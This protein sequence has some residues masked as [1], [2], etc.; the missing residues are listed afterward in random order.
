MVL[1]GGVAQASATGHPTSTGALAAQTVSGTAHAKRPFRVRAGRIYY[2][3][4]RLHGVH[5][6][7]RNAVESYY[8]HRW[9]KLGSWRVHRGEH[10]FVGKMRA[11]HPGLYKLRLQF[12]RH[13]HLLRGSASN[14]FRVRVLRF[15]HPKVRH[16]PHGGT[17]T[18]PSMRLAQPDDV[19][20]DWNSAE[21]GVGNN[22]GMIGLGTLLWIPSPLSQQQ[23][24]TFNV[25]QVIWVRDAYPGGNYG[26]WYV[27][28]TD[29]QSIHPSDPNIITITGAGDIKSSE[30][31]DDMYVNYQAANEYHQIAWD[32]AVQTSNGWQYI[33]STAY[34]PNSYVQWDQTGYPSGT[35]QSQYCY[36]Y[37]NQGPQ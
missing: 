35:Y 33:A 25:Y 36:T 14:S 1:V 6:G 17:S 9:H 21:C 30:Y 31:L 11:S 2:V 32:A 24:G 12:V 22:G 34:T 20:T 5:R 18:H 15:R 28:D 13:G 4:S 37:R 26:S 7:D 8:F 19:L 3:H 10:R 27:A 23:Q 16:H 29:E